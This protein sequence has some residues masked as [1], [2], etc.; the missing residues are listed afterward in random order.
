MPF[1]HIRVFVRPFSNVSAATAA[2]AESCVVR[3]LME[4]LINLWIKWNA[5]LSYRHGHDQN[6]GSMA[7]W[8]WQIASS[9]GS[10]GS[11]STLATS[12]RC[13]P[14]AVVAVVAPLTVVDATPGWHFLSRLSFIVGCIDSH[15]HHR[16]MAIRPIRSFSARHQVPT[17]MRRAPDALSTS[18]ASAAMTATSPCTLRR[19]LYWMIETTKQQPTLAATT[20]AEEERRVFLPA[21]TAAARGLPTIIVGNILPQQFHPWF[22]ALQSLQASNEPEGVCHYACKY[23]MSEVIWLNWR[24]KIL[25]YSIL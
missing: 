17:A 13:A 2:A 10:R 16:I 20:V 1:C 9:G 14:S 4:L 23:D 12:S 22:A 21:A 3:P 18:V 24:K 11:S 15:L 5:Q 7:N 19:R 6:R 8:R 25:D